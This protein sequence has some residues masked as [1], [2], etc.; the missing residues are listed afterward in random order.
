M[1]SYLTL[2]FK[3]EYGDDFHSSWSGVL[4]SIRLYRDSDYTISGIVYQGMN[5]SELMLIYPMI[6]EFGYVYSYQYED[7]D[8]EMTFAYDE[9]YNITSVIV[10]GAQ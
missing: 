6:D 10:S 5:L 4:E 3:V 1:R 9:N 2:K 7:E 8:Y